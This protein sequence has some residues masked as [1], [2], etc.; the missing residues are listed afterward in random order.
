MV[1]EILGKF[2]ILLSQRDAWISGQLDEF[3]ALVPEL[4]E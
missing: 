3:P 4:S 2:L 1:G